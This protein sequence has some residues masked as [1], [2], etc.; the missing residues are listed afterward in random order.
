ML[1]A[2]TSMKD[3]FADIGANP[4]AAFSESVERFGGYVDRLVQEGIQ[5]RLGQQA[6]T[7]ERRRTTAHLRFA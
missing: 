7:F 2:A 6:Q 3:V 1:E 4:E 5:I